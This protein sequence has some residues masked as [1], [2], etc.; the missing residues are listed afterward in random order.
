MGMVAHDDGVCPKQPDATPSDT[1]CP[2]LMECV[3]SP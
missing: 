2:I 1:P 3:K